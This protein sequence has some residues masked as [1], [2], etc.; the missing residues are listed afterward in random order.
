MKYYIYTYVYYRY[1]PQACERSWQAQVSFCVHTVSLTI[2]DPWP[3]LSA[4][5]RTVQQLC[6]RRTCV[7]RPKTL[8]MV[9]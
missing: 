2:D 7:S 6:D 9:P 3:I 4:L 5:F 1:Q 8:D